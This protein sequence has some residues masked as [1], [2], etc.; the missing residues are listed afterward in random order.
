MADE[1]CGYDRKGSFLLRRQNNVGST[2]EV[3]SPIVFFRGCHGTL[4]A[5]KMRV[6]IRFA[7]VIPR[8]ILLC[9]K[10][11]NR[12]RTVHLISTALLPNVRHKR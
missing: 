9:G 10:V 2:T 1:R 5:E 8:A 11:A 4:L 7:L 6:H 3:S 12:L